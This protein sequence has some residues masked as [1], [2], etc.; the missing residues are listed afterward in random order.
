M[1]L[2]MFSFIPRMRRKPLVPAI[3]LDG[4]IDAGG[5][6]GRGL[7]LYDLE[8]I[9]EP[10]FSFKHSRYVALVINSPGG[11][12][13]QSAL[14]LRRVRALAKKH[15]K[16]VFGFAEDVAASGGYLLALGADEIYADAS[17]MIGSIGVVSSG[18][19]FTQLLEKAGIERRLYTAGRSKASLDPFSPEDPE[20]VAKLKAMQEDVHETFKSLVKDRRGDKLKGDEDTLFNGDVWTGEKAVELGLIDGLG[21][22]HSVLQEK[23]GADVRIRFVESRRGFL[24]QQ[25]G[26]DMAHDLRG[27]LGSLAEGVLDAAEKRSLWAKFGR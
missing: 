6:F 21:D 11:S 12:P 27:L 8:E 16:T 20:E 14:I 1:S 22:M 25:L 18:F 15:N 2:P 4:V 9:L 26:L 24:R 13:V 5:R 10:A 17:T 23:V 3:R 19:G 7:N